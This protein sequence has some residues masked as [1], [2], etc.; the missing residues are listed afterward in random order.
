VS[1]AFTKE[2]GGDEPIVVAPRAPLPPGVPNRVTPR[3]LALL[4]AE[5]AELEEER[6]RILS[7][8]EDDRR[9]R[10]AR[11]EARLGELV[12]RLAS[13]EVVDP[14]SQPRDEVCFGASVVV[15]VTDGPD[16]GEE[17]RFRIVGVDEADPSRGR[18]AFLAPLAR[19]VLGRRVGDV[20]TVELPRGEQEIEIVEIGDEAD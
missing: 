14:R 6:S 7:A 15:A 9:R 3:G 18:I 5:L 10:L 12:P 17:R 4:R 1:K 16:A 13:A 8:E 11:V 20:V 2:D 19:A